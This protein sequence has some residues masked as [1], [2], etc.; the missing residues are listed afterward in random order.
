[1]MRHSFIELRLLRSIPRVLRVEAGEASHLALYTFGDNW[2]KT[3]GNRMMQDL[4]TYSLPTQ[5]IDIC[6]SL[7]TVH[8]PPSTHQTRCLICHW[9][10]SIIASRS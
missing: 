5:E 6:N 9:E 7:S 10:G 8:Y 2:G 3:F 1:M 4:V